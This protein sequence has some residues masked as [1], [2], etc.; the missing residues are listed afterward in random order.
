M[1]SKKTKNLLSEPRLISEDL[2]HP[3]STHGM[4]PLPWM[5][6]HQEYRGS[7][8]PCPALKLV[9]PFQEM[10]T[11]KTSGYCPPLHFRSVQLLKQGCH[12]EMPG[13]SKRETTYHLQENSSKSTAEFLPAIM[14]ARRQGDNILKELREKKQNTSTKTCISSKAIFQK[15]RRNTFLGKK[16]GFVPR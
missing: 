14:E 11:E 12:S 4:Q 5:K 3:A 9:V 7:D 2:S 10:Q 13:S 1:F 16:I 8:L 6:Y 15:W